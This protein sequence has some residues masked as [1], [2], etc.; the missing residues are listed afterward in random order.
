VGPVLTDDLC[1]I[2]VPLLEGP[3]SLPGWTERAWRAK[4]SRPHAAAGL[5]EALSDKR[6]QPLL[7]WVASRTRPSHHLGAAAAALAVLD[8]A[9]RDHDKG[10]RR[11]AR[12]IEVAVQAARPLPAR[13]RSQARTSASPY[14]ERHAAPD[15]PVASKPESPFLGTAAAL[16][17]RTGY[18]LGAD[19]AFTDRLV[20]A[21]DVVLSH[22]IAN[23]RPGGGLPE[24][25]PED[26]LRSDKRLAV[27]MGADRDLL[28]LV[29]G[30]QP[31]R[32][33]PLQEAR[34]R[35]LAYWVALSWRADR[36]GEPAP[37]PPA[38]VLAHW[39]QELCRVGTSREAACAG[40]LDRSDAP[41][42]LG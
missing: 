21:L 2:V 36:L 19:R 7:A 13:P 17:G 27:R 23:A 6:L 25:F 16:L 11:V 42:A 1:G 3:P 18:D 30:P 38:R 12:E 37:R 34:R 24:F 40:A 5:H 35:G 31:G 26:R 22:W 29:Y 39:R 41:S 28:Y 10:P 20:A 33:R 9:A 4:L 15:G 8:A 14:M 32:G